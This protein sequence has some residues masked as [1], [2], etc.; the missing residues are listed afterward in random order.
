MIRI[1]LKVKLFEI[2]NRMLVC[3]SNL[4][5]VIRSI[6]A[7]WYQANSDYYLVPIYMS[8]LLF[9]AIRL[10]IPGGSSERCLKWGGGGGG[11]LRDLSKNILK[12]GLGKGK[13]CS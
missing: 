1:Q 6:A 11:S 7:L 4:F 2:L 10:K 3:K 12:Q 13:S 8:N 5:L 9:E